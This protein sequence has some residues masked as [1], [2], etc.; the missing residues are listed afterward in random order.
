VKECEHCSSTHERRSKYCTLKCTNAA[1]YIKNKDRRAKRKKEYYIKN[2]DRINEYVKKWKED[3]SEHL[4]NYNKKFYQEN[5][6]Y[7]KKRNLAFDNLSKSSK[8][9]E[10]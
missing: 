6:D 9:G 8:V 5:K 1:Y 4:S 7:I 10:L 3:N 2:K